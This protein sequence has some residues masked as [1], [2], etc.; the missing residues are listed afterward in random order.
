M[1]TPVGQAGLQLLDL[2]LDALGDGQRILAVAHQHDAAVDFVAVLLEDAAAELR[3]ELHRGDVLDVDRR[4][5]D[6]LDDRVLDVLLVLDPADA[7]D[8]VLG[9]VLLDDAA[10]GRHVAL[11]DG[12]VELAQR[13]AVGPQVLGPHVDLIFQR[14]AAD[15]G[16][17]GHARRGVELRGDVELVERPQPAGV[18]RIARDWPR[19][20]TR[21][22]GP[23]PWRRGPGT[24]RRP[25]A[26][27]CW[28]GRASPSR[29]A[30]RS[31]SRC[32]PRR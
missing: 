16:H 32:C 17:L 12:R 14:R 22:S 29:A 13:D 19:R 20:C 11:A 28:P 18:D 24:A 2:L 25:A 15:D 3:A 8:D 9:I 6:L 1:C 10:A 27:T 21:R 5:V 30:G 23:A 7:A 4:A 31:R 26:E